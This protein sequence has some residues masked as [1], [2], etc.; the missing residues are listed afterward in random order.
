M[1]LPYLSADDAVL[2]RAYWLKGKCP[3]CGSEICEY[4]GT[5]PQAVAEGVT[6]C[7]RCIKNEHHLGPG[8]FLEQLLEVLIP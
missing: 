2:I 6:F 7:G 1:N 5:A 8:N 4:L 3:C